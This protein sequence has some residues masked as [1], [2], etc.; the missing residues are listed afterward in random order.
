MTSMDRSTN[1]PTDKHA[2]YGVAGS[3]ATWRIR[4]RLGSLLKQEEEK[5]NENECKKRFCISFALSL[6]I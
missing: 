2:N 3:D 6:K 4:E 1:Q 5:E